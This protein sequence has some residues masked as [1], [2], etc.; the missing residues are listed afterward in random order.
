MLRGHG[1]FFPGLGF[2]RWLLRITSATPYLSAD[3]GKRNFLWVV[4]SAGQRKKALAHLEALEAGSRAK[5]ISLKMSEKRRRTMRK[6]AVIH[7]EGLEKLALRNMQDSEID[8]LEKQST[9]ALAQK[10]WEDIGAT[11]FRFVPA[12]GVENV[13]ACLRA[14]GYLPG[15]IAEKLHVDL[16][17][18]CSVSA[19]LIAAQ[20]KNFN[21]AIV[22]MMDQKVLYDGVSGNVTKETELADRIASRRRKLHLD[23][24]KLSGEQQKRNVDAQL[25]VEEIKRKRQMYKERFGVGTGADIEVDSTNTEEGSKHE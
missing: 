11:Q 7:Q 25:T 3:P 4:L 2:G 10:H 22:T 16:S 23:A 15:E 14:A 24:L 17:V 20:R 5:I 9:L 8:K 19:T 1:K 12:S 6:R 13:I 21:E 18:V